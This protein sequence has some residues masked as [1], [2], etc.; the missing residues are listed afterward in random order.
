[1]MRT[2][3]FASCLGHLGYDVSYSLKGPTKMVYVL[4]LFREF[5]ER[6]FDSASNPILV[7]FRG[8]QPGAPIPLFQVSNLTDDE[9]T[10]LG[11]YLHALFAFKCIHRSSGNM[12]EDRFK[13]LQEKFSESSRPRPDPVQIS[14]ILLQQCVEEG[15]SWK[16][17]C[18]DLISQFNAGS[19]VDCKRLSELEQ[20]IV[21]IFPNLLKETQ[22]LI[23]YH[24]S[25]Y[26]AKTSGLAYKQLACDYVR[27]GSKPRLDSN[28]W[29]EILAPNMVKVHWFVARRI[30]FFLH[31]LG[32]AK[33]LRKRI[34][35]NSNAGAFRDLKDDETC[36][37]IT[38]LF[39]HFLPAFKELLT[40]AQLDALGN[41][42]MRGYLDVELV[43][44]F[45]VTDPELYASSFRMLQEFQS[46]TCRRLSSIQQWPS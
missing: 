46:M 4:R 25:N 14:Q 30:R 23:A 11:P 43:E 22:E 28:L 7:N 32:D 15:R 34:N 17:G 35:L 33:R 5:L 40:T 42:F 8:L 18:Q 21:T 29:R 12:K 19:G 41:K 38:A 45:R 20:V 13:A 16:D 36:W 37:G 6:P 1:M 27:F 2:R 31:K 3:S 44:K 39:V 10:L 24:W 9:M 26:P